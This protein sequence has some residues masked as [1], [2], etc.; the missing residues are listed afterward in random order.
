MGL[1]TLYEKQYPECTLYG[2]SVCDITHSKTTII[3]DEVL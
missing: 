1:C 2:I 3:L